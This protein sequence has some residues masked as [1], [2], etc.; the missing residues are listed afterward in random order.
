MF[1]TLYLRKGYFMLT[2]NLILHD[3]RLL[4]SRRFDAIASFLFVF[5]LG[6]F[7]VYLMNGLYIIFELGV[8]KLSFLFLFLGFLIIL[9]DS[10]VSE[11]SL[12]I[13]Y[14][15]SETPFSSIFRAK[16]IYSLFVNLIILMMVVIGFNHFSP[17]DLSF[18]IAGLFVTYALGDI[19]MFPILKKLKST[20]G[21]GFLD[22]IKFIVTTYIE[23][24][25]ALSIILF[26][27]MQTSYLHFLYLLGVGALVLSYLFE[28]G[29]DKVS[30]EVFYATEWMRAKA[31]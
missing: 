5:T 20:Y 10:L 25:I 6:Y 3:L 4:L 13:L 31:P 27:P 1:L 24:V 8:Y 17:I 12:L 21:V 7:A 11:K 2:L 28:R 30:I 26:I 9:Y 15:V 29:L 14:W 19:I 22:I 23:L 16:K 18:I